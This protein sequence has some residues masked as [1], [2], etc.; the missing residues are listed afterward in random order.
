MGAFDHSI[1]FRGEAFD[2]MLVK[3]PPF[4]R[5]GIPALLRTI[6]QKSLRRKNKTLAEVKLHL[7]NISSESIKRNQNTEIRPKEGQE[8][9]QTMARDQPMGAVI[10]T[11]SNRHSPI[12][13]Q[14]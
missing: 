13:P 11:M 3:S 12:A 4:A 10:L 1:R 2:F 8:T 9:L 5:R 14:R 6:I 7:R